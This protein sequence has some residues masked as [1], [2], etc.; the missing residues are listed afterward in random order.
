MIPE[1]MPNA[2]PSDRAFPAR[3]LALDGKG[4]VD[5]EIKRRVPLEAPIALEFNGIGYAVMMATP[6][7]LVP[8]VVG[9]SLAEGLVSRAADFLS[10]DVHQAEV[11]WIVRAILPS[12]QN[13]RVIARAR[14]R[15]SESSCGLCGLESIA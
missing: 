7:E 10:I 6:S 4:A 8:F 14:Q 9:F 13:E 3:R 15:V 12:S 1:V 5:E 11:G 2:T